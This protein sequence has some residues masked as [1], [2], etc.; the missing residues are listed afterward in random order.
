MDIYIY[1]YIC[2]RVCFLLVPHGL[3]LLGD[4]VLNGAHGAEEHQFNLEHNPL[5]MPGQETKPNHF[6]IHKHS[7]TSL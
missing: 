7:L 3:D 6:K 4:C 1:I 2:V 5:M